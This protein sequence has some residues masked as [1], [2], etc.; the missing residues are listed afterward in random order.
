[1]SAFRLGRKPS[2]PPGDQTATLRLHSPI[3]NARLRR[4][5]RLTTTMPRPARKWPRFWLLR[6]GRDR[7]SL[8]RSRSPRPAIAREAGRGRPGATWWRLSPLPVVPVAT[9]LITRSLERPRDHRQLSKRREGGSAMPSSTDE[10]PSGTR[11]R[12]LWRLATCVLHDHVRAG[13]GAANA[14]AGAANVCVRCR[15]DW[16]CACR[17]L[18]ERA[19]ADLA[20]PAR[21]RRQ[22]NQ[23]YLDWLRERAHRTDES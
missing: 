1:M 10:P 19:L 6:N 12:T 2:R 11:Q 23:G 22:R 13:A 3:H 20:R 7:G 15:E 4:F 16:P 18:A 5:L 9:P 14:G 21:V 8:N 17:K